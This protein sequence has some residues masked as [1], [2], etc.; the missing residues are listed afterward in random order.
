MISL[1]CRLIFHLKYPLVLRNKLFALCRRDG[2]KNSDE[3]ERRIIE[4]EELEGFTG[5]D[6]RKKDEG[7]RTNNGREI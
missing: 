7:R 3:V 2:I 5:K 1:I 6:E 4:Y